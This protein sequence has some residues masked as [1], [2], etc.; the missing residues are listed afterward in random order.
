M[1]D[2]TPGYK[3]EDYQCNNFKIMTSWLCVSLL[4]AGYYKSTQPNEGRTSWE[5]RIQLQ[6]HLYVT[7][8]A[9]LALSR[10]LR[11]V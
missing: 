6:E 10:G 9:A 3:E 8:Y 2:T 7:G 1:P 11:E 4:V 5:D